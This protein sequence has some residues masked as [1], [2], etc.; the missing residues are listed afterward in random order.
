M[1]SIRVGGQTEQ[2]HSRRGSSEENVKIKIRTSSVAAFLLALHCSSV[3]QALTSKRAKT[4]VLLGYTRIAI[5]EWCCCRLSFVSSFGDFNASSLPFVGGRLQSSP[6]RVFDK[7]G[8]VVK[9]CAHISCECV[10]LVEFSGTCSCPNCVP[11]AVQL[12]LCCVVHSF[13]GATLA[14]KVLLAQLR[15]S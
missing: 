3:G 12:C 4:F 11:V 8:L 6:S 2:K 13:R 10:G 7:K 9:S 14:E 15:F 1:Q 5:Q